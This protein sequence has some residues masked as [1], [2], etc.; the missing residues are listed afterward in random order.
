MSLAFDMPSKADMYYFVR[1]KIWFRFEDHTAEW[2]SWVAA[3]PEDDH[4]SKF[5]GRTLTVLVSNTFIEEWPR[6]YDDSNVYEYVTKWSGACLQDT[7]SGAGGFCL[8][9]SNDTVLDGNAPSFTIY[10]DID[11]SDGTTENRVQNNINRKM[12]IYRLSDDQFTNDFIPAWENEPIND[13]ITG[14]QDG[15]CFRNAIYD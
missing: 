15:R 1:D 8:L 7:S 6:D 14:L 9:E 13:S 4:V 12:Q 3:N 5:S 11:P 10:F 2:D